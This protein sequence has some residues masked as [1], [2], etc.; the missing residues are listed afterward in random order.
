MENFFDEYGDMILSGIA[1]AALIGVTV[2]FF[3]SS[4]A[5]GCLRSFIEHFCLSAL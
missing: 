4:G 3:T 2:L 1:A 5:A